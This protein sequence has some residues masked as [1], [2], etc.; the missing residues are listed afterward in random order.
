M[1]FTDGMFSDSFHITNG[2]RQVFL[3]SPLIFAL[4]M[5]PLAKKSDPT[6]KFVILPSHTILILYHSSWM[7]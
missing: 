6:W 3:L 2:T 4:L 7:M 1:V 5:E